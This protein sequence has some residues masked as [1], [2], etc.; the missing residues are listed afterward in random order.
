[1]Q[2]L[3]SRKALW[4]EIYPADA[5]DAPLLPREMRKIT[6]TVGFATFD[7]WKGPVAG[8][9]TELMLRMP[10]SCLVKCA[11]SLGQLALQSLA[12]RG[13]PVA[14][15]Y[16]ADAH[17]APLL[18]RQMRAITGAQYGLQNRYQL[19]CVLYFQCNAVKFANQQ[20]NLAR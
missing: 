20:L 10:P 18:P 5:H 14:G 11:Q 13:G 6:G 12:S 19:A 4:Q 16:P 8:K 15:K 1:M 2:R 9:Y 3:T 17:D 7:V